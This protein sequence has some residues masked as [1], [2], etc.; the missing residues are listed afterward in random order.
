MS[1]PLTLDGR[2]L[3]RILAPLIHR[4]E[5]TILR[6]ISRNPQSLP[7]SEKCAG[8]NIWVV[9]EVIKW[10]PPALGA[11]LRCSLAREFDNQDIKERNIPA[12]NLPP[13]MRSL[14]DELG[15]ALGRRV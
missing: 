3:A 11:V 6:D 7:P 15:A 1:Q 12:A 9:E 5:A 8:K 13:A 10:L 2:G 14:A 4:T